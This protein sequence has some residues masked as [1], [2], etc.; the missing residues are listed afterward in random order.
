MPILLIHKNTD[1]EIKA[2]KFFLTR[3]YGDGSSV[4]LSIFISSG[5]SFDNKIFSLTLVIKIEVV[6]TIFY[7][8]N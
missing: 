8:R 2:F 3:M 6:N 4:S 7:F 1:L 5:L